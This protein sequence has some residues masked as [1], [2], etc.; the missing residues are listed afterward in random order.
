MSKKDSILIDGKRYSLSDLPEKMVV[1]GDLDLSGYGLEELQDLSKWVIRGRFSCSNNKLTSL[2]GA[3][4]IVGSSFNCSN[5]KLTSLKGAPSKIA[6]YFNC[7]NN[8]LTSLEG[9]PKKLTGAYDCSW[10]NF[11]FLYHKEEED[12]AQG[13]HPRSIVTSHYLSTSG[14]FLVS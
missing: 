8:K 1:E 9:G 4:Q 14:W 7:S 5:N 3:P 12:K 6:G 10:N 2:K 13:L 11:S